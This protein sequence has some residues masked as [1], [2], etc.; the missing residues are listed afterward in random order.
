MQILSDHYRRLSSHSFSLDSIPSID[1]IGSEEI[2][3][4][5]PWQLSPVGKKFDDLFFVSNHAVTLF[6]FLHSGRNH[7]LLQ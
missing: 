3:S 2:I 5:R 7:A 6:M 4:D 1:Y